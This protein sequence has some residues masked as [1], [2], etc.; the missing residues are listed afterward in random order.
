MF[1]PSDDSKFDSS[2]AS[3]AVT[4]HWNMHSHTVRVVHERH[5]HSEAMGKRDFH[6]Y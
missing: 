5:I 3:R 6:L 1:V 2:D 4:K